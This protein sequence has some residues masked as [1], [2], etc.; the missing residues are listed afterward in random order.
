MSAMHFKDVATE[1]RI[2]WVSAIK[3]VGNEIC[4]QRCTEIRKLESLLRTAGYKPNQIGSI[5]H[6]MSVQ[7]YLHQLSLGKIQARYIG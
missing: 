4:D 2:A 5:A 7:E 1:L 6:G 3:D